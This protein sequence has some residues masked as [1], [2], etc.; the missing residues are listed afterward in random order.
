MRTMHFGL[1]VTDLVRSLE[2]YT[3]VGHEV[4]GRMPEH[5]SA[6]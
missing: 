5:P 4:I 2:F 3:A 1:R 6:T